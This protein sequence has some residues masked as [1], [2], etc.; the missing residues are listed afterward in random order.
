MKLQKQGETTTGIFTLP[1]AYIA[2]RSINL[3]EVIDVARQKHIRLYPQDLQIIRKVTEDAQQIRADMRRRGDFLEVT[4]EGWERIRRNMLLEAHENKHR[5][6]IGNFAHVIGPVALSGTDLSFLQDTAEVERER[7]NAA[8]E[9]RS[10]SE[11][12]FGVIN[13]PEA[14][15]LLV[16]AVAVNR[17]IG[18]IAAFGGPELP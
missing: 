12:R 17:I 5:A 14:A 13:D 6:Q 4:D 18:T 1:E 16:E 7:I 10:E 8:L 11:G 2:G 9:T 15:I 3:R